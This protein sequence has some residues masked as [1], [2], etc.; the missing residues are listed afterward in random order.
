MLQTEQASNGATSSTQG[1]KQRK[2]QAKRE[3]K[4]MLVMEQAKKATQKA[5]QKVTKAHKQ[6]EARQA[7]LQVLETQLATLRGV[8]HEAS[9]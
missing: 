6:L 9:S 7:H 1:T 4:I 5:E 2:K 8:D 3:A